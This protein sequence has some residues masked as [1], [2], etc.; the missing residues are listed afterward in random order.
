MLGVQ[1]RRAPSMHRYTD[2]S[3]SVYVQA[4]IQGRRC[5][6]VPRANHHS[7]PLGASALGKGQVQGLRKGQFIH[8]YHSY[9]QSMDAF[10]LCRY[11]SRPVFMP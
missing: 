5:E 3:C 11:K 9:I 7:P 10:I 4:D 2:G 1:D 6:A 8:S